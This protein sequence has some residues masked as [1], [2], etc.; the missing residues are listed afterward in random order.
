MILWPSKEMAKKKNK[1][2]LQ[3]KEMGASA[4]AAIS[5]FTV[6]SLIAA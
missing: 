4:H 3:W 5:D 2:H 1:K 6:K